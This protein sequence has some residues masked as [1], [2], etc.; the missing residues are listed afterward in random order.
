M[1]YWASK[2]ASKV[3]DV[4][5]ATCV[6]TIEGDTMAEIT[7][8]A[9]AADSHHIVSAS[10]DKTLKVWDLETGRLVA[11]YTCD[12]SVECCVISRGDI[13]IGGSDDG[14]VHILQLIV[15]AGAAFTPID[16]PDRESIGN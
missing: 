9:R 11:T 8:M 12:A 14:A 4:T 3:W 15:L 10:S 5:T 13:V 16:P 6:H 7:T 2:G 1:P